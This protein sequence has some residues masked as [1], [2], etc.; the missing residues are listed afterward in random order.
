MIEDIRTYNKLINNDKFKKEMKFLQHGDF[1]VY[2][3]S[4]YVAKTCFSIAKKL[5]INVDYNSL[6]KGAILHDYFLYDWHDSNS[7]RKGL[8]GFTHPKTARDNAVRDFGLNKK[9]EN[10]ILSHM[11]PL[12]F[13]VPTYKESIILCLADK[14]CAIKET[15]MGNKS[16]KRL[17]GGLCRYFALYNMVY[18]F[19]LCLS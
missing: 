17:N 18:L 13:V 2:D 12:G 6:V 10:M 9:E 15:I 3:H 8:H 5:N 11:F 14:Y 7:E 1:T 19:I 4:I 16:L